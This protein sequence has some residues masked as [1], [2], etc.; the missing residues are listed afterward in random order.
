MSEAVPQGDKG[1]KRM[2]TKSGCRVIELKAREKG[3]RK[4]AIGSRLLGVN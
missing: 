3:L 2:E 1:E 4:Q